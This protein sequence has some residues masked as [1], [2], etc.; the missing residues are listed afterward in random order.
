MNASEIT[1]IIEKDLSIDR[2]ILDSEAT[3]TPNIHS[4]YLTEYFASKNQ[5]AT[6]TGQRKRLWNELWVY[7]NGKA[8]PEVYEARPLDLKILKSDTKQFIEADKEMVDLDFK[9]QFAKN[10]IEMIQGVLDAVK[11]RPFLISSAI[12]FMAFKQGDFS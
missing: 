12:K 5:L 8:T 4:K 6:L 10:K 3:R 9:I 1:D 2:S 11:S 7:Y